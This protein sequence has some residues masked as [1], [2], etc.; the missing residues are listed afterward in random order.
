MINDSERLSEAECLALFDQ[1]FPNGFAA[2]DVLGEIAPEGWEHSAMLDVFHPSLEQ[3]FREAVQFHENMQSLRQPDDTRPVPAAPTREEIA[4]GFQIAPVDEEREVRELVGRCAWDIFSDNH[5]VIAS[6]GRVVDVG[7]FRGSG[8]FL[9][10]YLNARIP[11]ANY[12]YMDFY[13]GTSWI[14]C[15]ADVTPLYQMIF[16]R[17]KKFGCDWVYVFPKIHLVDLRPLREALQLN[18]QP[19]WENYDPSSGLAKEQQEQL[20]NQELTELRASMETDHQNAIDRAKQ[21]SPPFTV[22]AYQSIYRQ[23]PKG[24]PPQSNQQTKELG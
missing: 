21:S 19:E 7:S 11:N 8:G 3:V 22:T 6:D 1:M 13:M 14:T 10:D 4:N 17:L 16:R 12:D 5:E 18:D 20:R 2:G 24:W 15:R 9:A 23:F